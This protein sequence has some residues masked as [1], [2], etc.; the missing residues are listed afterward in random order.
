MA[1]YLFPGVVAL[2]LCKIIASTSKRELKFL[3]RVSFWSHKIRL[4][5]TTFIFQN[6]HIS[7]EIKSNRCLMIEN[8]RLS[9]L[10]ILNI[11]YF[12]I[13]VAK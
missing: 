6:P 3:K 4:I 12:A 8:F 13:I 11:L 5:G 2:S 9:S 7:R 10:N 1:E